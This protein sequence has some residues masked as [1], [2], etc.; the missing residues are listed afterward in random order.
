MHNLCIY[1]NLGLCIFYTLMSHDCLRDIIE[2]HFCK[3]VMHVII[4]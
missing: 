1:L 2:T 3:R 4:I